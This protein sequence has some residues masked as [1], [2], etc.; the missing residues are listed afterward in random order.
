MSG[1]NEEGEGN[2][3]VSE[4]GQ[5]NVWGCT[6]LILTSTVILTNAKCLTPD[7]YNI[8]MNRTLSFTNAFIK[9]G[10][11][12]RDDPKAKKIFFTK[13]IVHTNYSVNHN[14]NMQYNVALVK[15]SSY[16]FNVQCVRQLS[17]VT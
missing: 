9:A 11:T 4:E 2:E 12:N 15:V 17:K 13:G 14:Q 5:D 6:G 10:V 7:V 1:I 8:T 3:E 16:S